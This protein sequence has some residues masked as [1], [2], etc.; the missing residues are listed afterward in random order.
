M[1]KDTE[2]YNKYLQKYCIKNE[3]ERQTNNI[4]NIYIVK[5]KRL[6]KELNIKIKNFENNSIIKGIKNE[7]SLLEQNIKNTQKF[8]NELN[9]YYNNL[10]NLQDDYDYDINN[11]LLNVT[12]NTIIYNFNKNNDIIEL[13]E[14]N[15]ILFN[16]YI[17]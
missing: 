16:D 12:N 5:T 9:I 2:I 1:N 3:I 13:N 17:E 8:I 14:E 4:E 6:F 11:I 15:L 7:I 10:E